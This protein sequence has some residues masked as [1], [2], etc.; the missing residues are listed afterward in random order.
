VGIHVT[1]GVI[2]LKTRSKVIFV[3]R[4]DYSGLQR[5]AHIGTGNYHAGT[6]RQYNDIGLLTN[7]PVICEDLNELFN[8]LT[9]G[10][11]P[12]RNYRKILPSPNKLKKGLLKKIDR[13]ILPAQKP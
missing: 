3:V 8:Y 4:R 11:A 13:E 1:Y 5:Y 2:G 12:F 10:Y 9:T 7:D 6:A